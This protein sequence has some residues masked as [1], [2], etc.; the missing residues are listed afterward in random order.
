[1]GHSCGPCYNNLQEKCEGTAAAALKI[2]R[3][4]PVPGQGKQASIT[5]RNAGGMTANLTGMSLASGNDTSKVL[6]LPSS[7]SRQCVDNST[8][9]PGQEMTFVT[10]SDAQRCGFEFELGPR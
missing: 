3:V 10:K 2:V 7:A 9:E 5:I 4:V 6:T 1:M 8:I